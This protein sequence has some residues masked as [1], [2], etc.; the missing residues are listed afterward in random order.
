MQYYKLKEAVGRMIKN[1]V[2]RWTRLSAADQGLASNCVFREYLCPGCIYPAE[3][4]G[5]YFF[6]GL[7]LLITQ[8]GGYWVWAPLSSNKPQWQPSAT[9]A[10]AY[11]PNKNFR[12]LF[13]RFCDQFWRKIGLVMHTTS[14]GLWRFFGPQNRQWLQQ[15]VHSFSVFHTYLSLSQSWERDNISS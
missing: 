6:I 8:T 4:D 2:P 1:E 14:Y 5:N 13:W 10:F 15:S 9:S 7:W 12:L 3:A 11:K